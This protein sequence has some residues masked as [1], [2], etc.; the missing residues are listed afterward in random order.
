MTK[1]YKRTVKE[2]GFTL[3]EIL[4]VV[5][6]IGILSAIAI[7]VFNNQR[8]T[9]NDA[10]VVSDVK[11]H[12][13]AM[14]TYFTANPNAEFVPVEEIRKMAPKSSGTVLYIMGNKNDYC[15]FGYHEN[16]KKYIGGLWASGDQP[17]LTYS[18]KKAGVGTIVNGISGDD[19][20]QINR[21]KV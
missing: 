18:S 6:V 15:V 5:L 19:C 2:D 7:P 9:A 1:I 16:G 21:F 20:Y 17:Y 4:V 14:Q 11:N 3:I 8:Q 13:L 12:G 10:A